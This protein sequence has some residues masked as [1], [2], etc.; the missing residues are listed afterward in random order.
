MISWYWFV[1]L[2]VHCVFLVIKKCSKRIDIGFALD[3]SGSMGSRS[4][5]KE[6]EF[7]IDMLKQFDLSREETN[8]GVIVYSLHSKLVIKLNEFYDLERFRKALNTRSPWKTGRQVARMRH[9]WMNHQ[10]R[11]DRALRMASFE[12]FTKHN[13][14]RPNVRN[15]LIF[16]T[17][18][19]QNPPAKRPLEYF[20]R[21]LLNNKV[22]IIAVGFGK[23]QR[24]ELL[25]IASGE[26]YTLSYKGGVEVL[27]KAVGEI[28]DRICNCK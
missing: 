4:F 5:A 15:V 20:A 27:E 22:N 11:I 2:Y 18:G 28:V 24:D 8:A 10:T 25:K 14:D 7:V 1:K 13:G 26:D 19:I 9:K 23:S 6:R 3:A 21:P 16:L 12:F 17:D